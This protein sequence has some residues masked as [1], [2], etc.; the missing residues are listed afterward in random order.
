[1][2]LLFSGG[3]KRSRIKLMEQTAFRELVRRN[4]AGDA[5]ALEELLPLV[6]DQLRRLAASYLRSERPG[7]TLAPTAVVHEAWLR[8]AGA[9]FEWQDRAHFL[10]LIA[11]VMRRVLVD[12]ART[13]DRVK[14][15]DGA[16]RLSLDE[17]GDLPDQRGAAVGELDEALDRLAK[18]DPRKA[19]VVE[20][21]FF[22]G[23]TYDEAAAALN[24]SHVT[25]HRDLRLAKAWLENQLSG[26]GGPGARAQGI[27]D[28]DA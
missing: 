15:G 2:Q 8:L 18:F 10:A 21:I 22:G 19:R 4:R 13:R 20:L 11:G 14:R 27:R 16:I 28:A 6:Y 25:I 24:V 1:V 9:D 5:A 3:G 23:A 7:H 26:A 12:H 17:A